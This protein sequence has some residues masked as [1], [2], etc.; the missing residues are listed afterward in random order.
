MKSLGVRVGVEHHWVCPNCP[1]TAITRERRPHT[2]F[3]TCAGLKGITAPFVVDGVRC[4]VEAIE[5]GDYLGRDIPQRDGDGRPIMA[6]ITTRDDGQDCAV[7]A[8]TAVG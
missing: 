1:A 4:K 2:H 3:H 6:V 5:R 8:A 7:L